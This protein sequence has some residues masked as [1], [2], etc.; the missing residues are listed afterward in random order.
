MNINVSIYLSIVHNPQFVWTFIRI[1]IAIFAA[2][3]PTVYFFP[4]TV[5]VVIAFVNLAP[6]IFRL[7]LVDF[8]KTKSV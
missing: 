6:T 7:F 8:S 1:E 2:E 4:C 5:E 3:T